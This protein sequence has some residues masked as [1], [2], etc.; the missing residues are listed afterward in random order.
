LGKGVLC[1]TTLWGNLILGPTARDVYKA[2][3]RDMSPAAIQEY[4]LSKCKHLVPSF[5]A[6]EA[7]HAFCGARA[8]STR[9][10]WIIEHSAKN[11]R[12]ILVAGIDS[13]GLAGSPAS[14]YIY[15]YIYLLSIYMIS[16]LHVADTQ[17]LSLF[18]LFLQLR[19]KW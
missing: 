13:P 8:K 15:I 4:I 7:I 17:S 9:G 5:D 16:L 3:A 2:E 18:L 6:K 1:Q 14:M 12:M 19:K 11:K 10:D